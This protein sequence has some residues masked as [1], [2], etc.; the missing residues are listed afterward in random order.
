MCYTFFILSTFFC[1][2]TM[3]NMLIA[4]MGDTFERITENRALY[5]TLTKLGLMGELADVIKE[6]EEDTKYFMFVVTP[7]EKDDDEF[8]D[9]EGSIK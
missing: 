3:L 1:Q 4:I 2:L 7:D 9:W 6:R 8:G 5:S